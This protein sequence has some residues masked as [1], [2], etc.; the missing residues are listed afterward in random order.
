MVQ[1]A[2]TDCLNAPLVAEMQ[3]HE[4][5]HFFFFITAIC[6]AFLRMVIRPRAAAWHPHFVTYGSY[7]TQWR[8]NCINFVNSFCLYFFHHG[9]W[10]LM[11]IE[12]FNKLFGIIL[13]SGA[14]LHF[15]NVLRRQPADM[16]CM[17]HVWRRGSD[18]CGVCLVRFA[19]WLMFRDRSASTCSD[20]S[21]TWHVHRHPLHSPVWRQVHSTVASAETSS[22]DRL[23]YDLY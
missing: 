23:W 3:N 7:H 17:W 8:Y 19:S 16:C 2:S 9:S 4:L 15:W 18:D 6:K 5:L 22:L 11:V 12:E 1:L 13:Y 10:Y 20:R 14:R 21:I